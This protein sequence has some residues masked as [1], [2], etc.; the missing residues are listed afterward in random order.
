VGAIDGEILAIQP[1]L[2]CCNSFNSSVLFINFE[3]T[4]T[5]RVTKAGSLD[6][7]YKSI[8]LSVN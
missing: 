1:T 8:Y 5:R 7:L 6:R 3:Q 2:C 4:T